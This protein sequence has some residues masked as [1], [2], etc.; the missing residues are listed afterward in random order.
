MLNGLSHDFRSTPVYV[1][2]E[3]ARR[4]QQADHIAASVTAFPFLNRLSLHA[5]YWAKTAAL[6]VVLKSL[7]LTGK[8]PYESGDVIDIMSWMVAWGSGHGDR[9]KA[10][11]AL[12]HHLAFER[13]HSSQDVRYTQKDLDDAVCQAVQRTRRQ[14]CPTGA[15]DGSD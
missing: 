5:D 15:R 14:C 6:V 8:K 12:L 13:K 7:D 9:A 11:E 4:Q 2:F 1:G 10:T 3:A